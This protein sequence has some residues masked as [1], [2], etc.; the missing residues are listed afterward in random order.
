VLVEPLSD[1]IF[2]QHRVI[3]SARRSVQS[4]S[5]SGRKSRPHPITDANIYSQMLNIRRIKKLKICRVFNVYCKSIE[6]KI[7]FLILMGNYTLNLC[8]HRLN[9]KNVYAYLNKGNDLLL[10]EQCG[11]LTFK[12][13]Y[14]FSVRLGNKL[15]MFASAIGIALNSN[16]TFCIQE[17]AFLELRKIF[18]LKS[19][20]ICEDPI[21]FEKHHIDKHNNLPGHY[22]ENRLN[23]IPCKS[24]E[25]NY[26]LQSYKYFISQQNIIFEELSIHPHHLHMAERKIKSS[27]I[28]KKRKPKNIVMA[29][30][31]RGDFLRKD[32]KQYGYVTVG[33]EYILSAF[34]QIV[35]R[36][37]LMINETVLFLV[38]DDYHWIKR[39]FKSINYAG[40]LKTHKSE[41]VDLALSQFADYVIISTGTFSWW[42]GFLSRKA[43]YRPKKFCSKKLCNDYS[44]DDFMPPHWIAIS[45]I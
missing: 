36:N 41:A 21:L 14:E 28:Y 23:K 30:I 32:L 6:I 44:E 34:Y 25:L 13:E 26:Y 19:F 3:E 31:R 11:C 45:N 7:V 42:F 27:S 29:H 39:K 16:R 37:R 5:G 40:A 20:S 9:E 35:R 22:H 15:F 4:D 18:H 8:Y 24:L 1:R 43:V 12:Q 17:K 38:S 33:K 2:G 10:N